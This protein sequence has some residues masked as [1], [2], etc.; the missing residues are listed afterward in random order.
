MRQQTEH[1]VPTRVETV[2]QNAVG[3]KLRLVGRVLSYEPTTG[4]ALLLDG[5]QGLIL[6]VS[7]CVDHYS[8]SWTR[9]R[10]CLVMV[11]GHLETSPLLHVQTDLPIPII[12]AHAPTPR[13]DP[14]L[15]LQAVLVTQCADLDVN[16]WNTA[17]DNGGTG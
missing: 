5:E 2:D 11:V 8:S 6:D 12:P 9:E 13:L 4:M 15:V 14:R 7:L 3:R 16:L 1:A 10:L 17:I